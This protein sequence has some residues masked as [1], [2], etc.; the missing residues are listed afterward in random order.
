[1]YTFIIVSVIT[2]MYVTYSIVKLIQKF[3]L[4]PTK[5]TIKNGER[6]IINGDYELNNEHIISRIIDKGLNSF[7][8]TF[9]VTEKNGVIDFKIIKVELTQIFAKFQEIFSEQKISK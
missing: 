7:D 6:S 1:M 5:V 9:E 2:V 4:N 8:M 3:M